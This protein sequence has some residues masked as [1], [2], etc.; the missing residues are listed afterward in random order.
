MAT[1]GL[2]F[3][4]VLPTDFR[5]EARRYVHYR[6]VY[7]GIEPITFH[8]PASDDYIDIKEA[9][10][11]I[12]V[13]LKNSATG[14]AGF[15][16]PDTRAISDGTNTKNTSIVNNFGHTFKQINVKYNG[17][18]MTEQTNLYHY[19]AYF[20]TLLNYSKEGESKL[21]PQ[22][23]VNGAL[24]ADAQLSV[25][26]NNT[27]IILDSDVT[28]SYSKLEAL[29]RKTVADNHW[30]TF[31]IKPY[32]PVMQVGGFL[33]PA[34][35]IEME[36]LMNPN[37]VYLYGTPNKGT[38]TTKVFP[39]ITQEDIKVTLV[40]PKMTLNSSVFNQL[41]SERS[42]T[43]KNITYPVVRTSIRT[44]SRPTGNTSWEQDDVFLNKMPDR[45][46]LG[47][48]HTD[49]YNG[50]F[51]RYPFAFERFGAISVRQTVNGEYP[52]KTLELSNEASNKNSTDYLGYERFLQASGAYREKKIP[53]LQPEDCLTMCPVAT[54]TIPLTETPNNQAMSGIR[55]TLPLPPRTISP[56]WCGV[57]TRLYWRS[58]TKEPFATTS[59]LAERSWNLSL[60]PPRCWTSWPSKIGICKG[61]F[62]GCMRRTDYPD[63]D[64]KE[65]TLSIR[66]PT[67]SWVDIGWDCGWTRTLVKSLTVMVYPYACT[68]TPIYSCG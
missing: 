31:V 19:L 54:R 25:A 47:M 11:L 14:H 55:S 44:F 17:I 48:V 66:I 58:T 15:K 24:N 22:G 18:L 2:N 38:L 27:N 10:L 62:K 43:K 36:L 8:V 63:T 28:S 52:Y 37:T 40:I 6:P 39:T 53:M 5:F 56:C 46:M 4:E 41:Q 9:K 13:R 51:T 20:A 34:T 45:T 12:T 50:D 21:I 64:Q 61:S 32:V 67:T 23:W 59:K 42:L 68:T 33:I 1:T 60:S 16:T 65:V 57:N 26:A 35:S 3:F 30:F 49:A 29:T 7:Q